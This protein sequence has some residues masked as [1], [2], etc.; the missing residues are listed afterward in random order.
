[1]QKEI[2]DLLTDCNFHYE[3]AKFHNKDYTEFFE[4]KFLKGRKHMNQKK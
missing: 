3:S 4:I 2:E 1:M